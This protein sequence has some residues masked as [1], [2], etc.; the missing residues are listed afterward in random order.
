MVTGDN[1]ETAIAIAKDCNILDPD[2]DS[3]KQ[4]YT[5]LEGKK[6]RELVGGL[7]REP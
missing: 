5:A 4:D 2:Y 6:F 7:I 1:Y 3:S